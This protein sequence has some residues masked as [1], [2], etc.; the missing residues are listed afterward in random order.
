MKEDLEPDFKIKNILCDVGSPCG[1]DD[2]K[3]ALESKGLSLGFKIGLGPR[4]SISLV[5]F[6]GLEPA[7]LTVRVLKSFT[8]K[9][10]PV[11]KSPRGGNI[12]SL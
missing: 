9:L 10:L 11:Q 8:V 7:K 3:K 6:S 4:L 1:A 12:K 2:L 5:G